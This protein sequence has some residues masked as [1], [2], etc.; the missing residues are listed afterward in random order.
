MVEDWRNRFDCGPFAFYFVQIA[1]YNYRDSG[2]LT[3]RLREQQDRTRTLL[4]NSA[5]VVTMDVGDPAD[6]HP[7]RK[8]VVGRRLADLALNRIH[9]IERVVDSPEYLSVSYSKGRA[10]LYLSHAAGLRS[11]GEPALF[12]IAGSDR[13]FVPAKARIVGEAIEIWSDQVAEPKAV[14]YGWCEACEGNVWNGAG[15]PLAPFRTDRD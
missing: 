8:Q 13:R 9:G 2:E 4:P 3:V 11:E 14:R 1:P 15:L 5:M 6:I 12:Q 10:L 7:V